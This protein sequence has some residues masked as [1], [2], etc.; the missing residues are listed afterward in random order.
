MIGIDNN[1]E[2]ILCSRENRAAANLARRITLI[3]SDMEHVP[4]ASE[5]A[6]L[7][8]T[9]LPF[10]NLSGSH[11]A[12]QALYPAILREARRLC[13][14]GGRFVIL[15]HEMRLLETTIRDVGGW[16]IE[17]SAQIDLRGLHPKA[18]RLRA[19]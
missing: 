14:T 6:D 10:G 11:R 1:D 8:L 19:I 12:N 7:L 5:S 3:K 15:T 18:Y 4:L 9:D 17:W 13:R 2:A 16:Q